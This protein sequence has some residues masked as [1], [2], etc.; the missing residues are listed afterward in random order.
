[1]NA[2]K[3]A[4]EQSLEELRRI[5]NCSENLRTFVPLRQPVPDVTT[6]AASSLV[7]SALASWRGQS[8]SAGVEFVLQSKCNDRKDS[9]E[10][11]ARMSRS[12]VCTALNIALSDMLPLLKAGSNLVVLVEEESREFLIQAGRTVSGQKGAQFSDTPAGLV[13]PHQDLARAIA[14]Q[15]G[16]RVVHFLARAGC[17]SAFRRRFEPRTWPSRTTEKRGNPCLAQS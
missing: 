2:S 3:Y 17:S 9:G 5:I 13:T 1:V 6:F 15:R 8:A 14:C 4:V 7:E 10:G 16:W 11:R 12:S